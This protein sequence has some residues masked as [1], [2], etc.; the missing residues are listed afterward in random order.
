MDHY[1]YVIV[2]AGSAGCV[3]AAR[4]SEDPDASVLLVEAGGEASGIATI[5]DPHLWP[6][7]A[8]TVVDWGYD[9]EVQPGT[10]RSHPFVRGRVIGGS[11]AINGMI[12]LRGDP[13]VYDAWA[14][15]GNP[16]WDFESVLPYFQ[17]SETVE[18]RDRRF[19]G[20]EGPLRPAPVARPHPITRSFIDACVEARHPRADDVNGASRDGVALHDLNI[21]DGVRQSAADAYL[22]ATVRGRPNL[23][24]EPGT[25]VLRLLR[26]SDRCVGVGVV[27]NGVQRDIRAAEEVILTAGAIDTPRLLMLS[28]IGPADELTEVGINVAVDLPAVGRNLQDHTVT[29]LVYEARRTIAPTMANHGEASLLWHSSPAEPACDL[30]LLMCDVAI[31]SMPA[32]ANCCTLLVANLR[33]ASRGRTRLRSADPTQPPL[34]ALNFLGEES[35]LEKV[36][37]GL[38]TAR[39]IAAAAAFGD[40]GLRE[41]LPG[42]DGGTRDG[43]T[44]FVRAAT[45]TYNHASGTCRMGPGDDSVVDSTLKVHGLEALRVAD[46]SIV[47]TIPNANTHATVVMIGEKAADLIR[48]PAARPPTRGSAVSAS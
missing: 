5:A 10:G 43:L 36:L 44:A 17:R 22:T 37:L 13:T 29:G 34:I 46:A 2:G 28:G 42:P 7:N 48:A 8:K 45:D 39:E 40:W 33:P 23:V 18:G 21:V 31:T 11:S 30:H 16:G 41:V 24:I 6:A 35:D 3:L 38:A 19:R 27:A 47:P 4:L 1:D 14:A 26:A 25:R 12:F 15:A 32:P 20:G 9:T